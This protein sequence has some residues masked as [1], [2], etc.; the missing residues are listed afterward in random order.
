MR[1]SDLSIKLV[2]PN[3]PMMFNN[4]SQTADKW[5]A[6]F[7]KIAHKVVVD[8]VDISNSMSTYPPTPDNG[9][10][11]AP[12]QHCSSRRFSKDALWCHFLCL[13]GFAKMCC[14]AIY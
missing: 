5:C 6:K 14:G 12:E 4:P 8:M 11:S 13:A 7:E 1:K 2:L 3:H 9:K 10:G